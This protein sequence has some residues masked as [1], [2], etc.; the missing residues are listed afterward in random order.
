MVEQLSSDI[1]MRAIHGGPLHRAATQEAFAEMLMSVVADLGSGLVFY[2]FDVP[3][4]F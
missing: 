3:G 4:A 2:R 1:G